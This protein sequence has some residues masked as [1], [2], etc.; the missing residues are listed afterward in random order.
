M[1]P[2]LL[3]E[4]TPPL[5]STTLEPASRRV[6]WNAYLPADRATQAQAKLPRDGTAR[7]LPTHRVRW[8]ES[9]ERIAEAHG[10]AVT[11]LETLNDLHPGEAPRPGALLFVPRQVRAGEAPAPKPVVVVPDHEFRYQDRRRVFYEAVLGDTIEDVARVCGVGAAELQRWNH[12]DPSAA[13]QTG[14]RL[15]LFLPRDHVPAGVLLTE[16]SEA[17]VLTVGSDPFHDHFV[18]ASGRRRITVTVVPG[19]SWSGIAR[20]YGSTLG[21]LERINQRSRRSDLVPGE[22]LIVYARSDRVA[23]ER[24][25]SPPETGAPPSDED[26]PEPSEPVETGHAPSD[27]TSL[28]AA[29]P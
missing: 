3:A 9:L 6:S 15:Q 1:N 12:L 10:A 16:V 27:P 21:M 20:R 19:D 29:T 22:T 4:R 13:L 23:P 18:G 8:G 2:H 17:A 24:S 26:A 7:S 5:E 28:A 25:A 11:T 14:M